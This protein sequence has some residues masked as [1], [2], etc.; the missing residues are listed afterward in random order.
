MKRLYL[1]RHAKSSWSDPDLADY[2]RPLSKR[3]K[4]NAELMANLLA[5]EKFDPDLIL[6]SGAKRTRRTLKPLI[7]ALDFSKKRIVY[8]D[9]VY[10][11]GLDD[12]LETIGAVSDKVDT[13][14]LVAHNPSLNELLDHLL[15][16]HTIE[17][18]VTGGFVELELEIGH[19][20]DIAGAHR[21]GKLVRFEYPKKHY[22][23][24]APL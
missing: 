11:A 23:E 21:K 1:Y 6:C 8:T 18:I 2:D 12:L 14:L 3:G 24:H 10:E 15:K 17:N 4:H 9:T 5:K 7:R 19:W 22:D 20:S 16:D 13:L